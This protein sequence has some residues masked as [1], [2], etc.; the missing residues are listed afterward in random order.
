MNL[1]NIFS[2]INQYQY[3]D[4]GIVIL[5]EK[6]ITILGFK[7]KIKKHPSKE[8]QN[9]INV[10]SNFMNYNSKKSCYQEDLIK[11]LIAVFSSDEDDL[12]CFSSY[13]DL[14]EKYQ[15]VCI[16][17][18]QFFKLDK[19]FIT[20]FLLFY[21]K[22][23]DSHF[24]ILDKKSKLYLKHINKNKN[25]VCWRYRNEFRNI[26]YFI[27]MN[28]ND[29]ITFKRG[30]FNNEDEIST[31]TYNEET[32]LTSKYVKG[33]CLREYINNLPDE[34]KKNAL[35][36]FFDYIFKNY[37][38]PEDETSV[39]SIDYQIANFIINDSGE[40]VHIDEQL[41]SNTPIKKGQMI[42]RV[43][44]YA[45]IKNIKE[46]FDYFLKIY[47]LEY[48]FNTCK[49]NFDNRSSIKVSQ[50]NILKHKQLFEKYFGENMF[51]PNIED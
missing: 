42:Y 26:S 14:Y 36:N 8:I 21:F 44:K 15:S 11:I 20:D 3:N 46:L 51:I 2:I 10:L 39:I 4:Y 47:N 9:I 34:D 30:N 22:N 23:D 24:H 33:V 43:L 25:E 6:I 7:I 31:Y 19:Q 49:E 32:T 45:Q 29:E 40:Y 37:S 48:D 38:H 1:K 17:S 18:K 16:F 35:K 27:I 12:F 5:K 28:D 50:N 13:G 41:K